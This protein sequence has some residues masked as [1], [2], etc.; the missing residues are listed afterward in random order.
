MM[1]DTAVMLPLPEFE[2][3]VAMEADQMRKEEPGF[4]TVEGD[5]RKWRGFILGTGIY[6]GGVFFFEIIVPREF[7]F[8]SPN[9]RILTPIY[10]PNF[11]KDRVCIGVLGKEWLPCYSLVNV[12]ESIRFLLNNPNPDDPLDIQCAKEFKKSFKSFKKKAIEMVKKHATWE[13]EWAK[14]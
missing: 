13:Q 10:H 8:K 4:Q 6:E 5:V 2:A 11:R 14:K 1:S 9:V 7:P 12:V 3:R